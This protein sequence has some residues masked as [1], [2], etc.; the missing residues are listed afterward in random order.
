MQPVAVASGKDA[1]DALTIAS[2]QGMP[3]RLLLL[4]AQ[5]P[6]VDGFDV[7]AEIGRRPELAGLTIM[8]L[9]SGGRYGDSAR[10][11]ELGISAYLPKPVKQS[12]L[13]DAICGALDG[14]Q[15]AAPKRVPAP[16]SYTHLTLPTILRV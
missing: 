4:D 15:E 16:V 2:R 1:L 11:R 5:M 12:D 6:G 3:F 14:P 10:C 8:M 13:F 9:T 7:A